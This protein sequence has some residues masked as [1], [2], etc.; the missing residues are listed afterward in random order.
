MKTKLKKLAL[1]MI[2]CGIIGFLVYYFCHKPDFIMSLK[3]GAIAAVILP[4][5]FSK[6]AH[7]DS[8]VFEARSKA[9]LYNTDPGTGAIIAELQKRENDK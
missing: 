4:V 5:S 2:I 1:K 9:F 8:T 6:S 3:A 7:S